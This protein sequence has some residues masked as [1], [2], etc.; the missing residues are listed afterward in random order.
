MD[1]QSIKN[2]GNMPKGT[3]NL[4]FSLSREYLDRLTDRAQKGESLGVCAKRLLIELLDSGKELPSD[5]LQALE[6]KMTKI[7]GENI[8]KNTDKD[9]FDFELD[10]RMSDLEDK[11]GE[12]TTKLEN[13]TLALA[14][15]HQGASVRIGHL[16]SQINALID[17]EL[18]ESDLTKLSTNEL[19]KLLNVDRS[20]ITRWKQKG[21]PRLNGWMQG[22]DGKWIKR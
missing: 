15:N 13:L 5:R 17:K 6:E 10:D 22:D 19:A 16:E 9:A 21:D 20:T 14:E 12:L 8:D 7:I 4:Q 11:I 2:I 1:I 18:M 3:N